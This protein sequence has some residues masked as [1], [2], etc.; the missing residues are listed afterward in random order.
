MLIIYLQTTNLKP[1]FNLQQSN[2]FDI[3]NFHLK[4]IYKL[5]QILNN[6]RIL[7]PYQKDYLQLIMPS[8]LNIFQKFFT[9]HLMGA[10]EYIIYIM[11][12]IWMGILDKN[13]FSLQIQGIQPNILYINPASPFFTFY[14]IV[15]Y[16]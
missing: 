14:L 1:S 13:K 7:I 4:T 16:K 10:G 5:L 11:W 6:F 9:I 8:S 15:A 3:Q 12:Y 2:K